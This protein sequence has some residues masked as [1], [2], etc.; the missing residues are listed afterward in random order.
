MGEIKD[1]DRCWSGRHIGGT[2]FPEISAGT[3]HGWAIAA[4]GKCAIRLVHAVPSW[5]LTSS[6]ER[7]GMAVLSAF[8]PQISER[9]VVRRFDCLAMELRLTDSVSA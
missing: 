5:R 7:G 2:P 8:G 4:D 3:S 1:V 9:E 6:P